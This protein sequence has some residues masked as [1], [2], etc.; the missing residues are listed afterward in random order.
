MKIQKTVWQET[1]HIAEGTAALTAV[2]L[3]VFAVIG[4]FTAMVAVSGLLGAA[5]AV[6]NFFLLGLTVQKAT[7]PGNEKRSRSIMQFS[8]SMRM[9]FQMAVLFL[10]F[11][12]PALHW[13]AVACPLLFPRVT[14][15]FM[16][17]FQKFAGKEEKS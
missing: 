14:I 9:L 15:F 5:T 3:G 2:M 8:Y 13:V 10:G 6:L 12:I 1:A 11:F 17:L 16:G 7:K 4:K